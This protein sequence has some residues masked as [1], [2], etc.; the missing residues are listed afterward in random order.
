M[1]K[2]NK[3]AALA[4][5]FVLVFSL[6][7]VSAFAQTEAVTESV[8]ETVGESEAES[9]RLGDTPGDIEISERV[10]FA[11]QGTVTGMVMVFAV[12]ALLAIVVSI[13]KVIFYDIPRKMRESAAAEQVA[14]KAAPVEEPQPAPVI[15]LSQPVA[16]TGTDDQLIAVITAAVAAAL[17]GDEYNGQFE[18]G[19]RVVSFRRADN[20]SAWNKR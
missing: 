8:A 3:I 5:V 9:T 17:E 10:E 15:R 14:E 12:L 16:V 18:S 4:L 19:F 11:L 2:I 1:K 20:G 6:F 13:S 7:S